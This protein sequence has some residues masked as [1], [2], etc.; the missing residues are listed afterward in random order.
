MLNGTNGLRFVQWFGGAANGKRGGDSNRGRNRNRSRSRG[1]NWVREV[2]FVGGLVL[3]LGG[4]KI[5]SLFF[6]D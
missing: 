1:R 2:V 3:L 6:H 4:G 5:A